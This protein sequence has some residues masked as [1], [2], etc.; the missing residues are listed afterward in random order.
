[1]NKTELIH[2]SITHAEHESRL[3]ARQVRDLIHITPNS[4]IEEMLVEKFWRY[5]K[6]VIRD[7]NKTLH[8]KGLLTNEVTE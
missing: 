8:N 5:R 3:W 7:H 1:M 2:K 4:E 6:M